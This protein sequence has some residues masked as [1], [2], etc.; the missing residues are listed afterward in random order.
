LHE[1]TDDARRLLEGQ[2]QSLQSE[3]TLTK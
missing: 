3:F 2:F 1:P